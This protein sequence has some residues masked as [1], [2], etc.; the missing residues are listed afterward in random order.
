MFGRRWNPEL[1]RKTVAACAL[2]PDLDMLE[3]GDQTVVGDRGDC[4]VDV[5]VT[6]RQRQLNL[7]LYM[8]WGV[9]AGIT[10]SGGQ[11]ARVS[12]ARAMYSEADV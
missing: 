6:C 7:V 2:K 12:L 1:Y 3:L 9:N 10:L 11:K 5:G 4:F 8:C